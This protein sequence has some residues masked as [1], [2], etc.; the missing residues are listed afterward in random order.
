MNIG[1]FTDTYFPQVN[2]V[3]YTIA[4]WK[5]KLEK[6]HRVSVYYP[7]GEYTPAVGEYP[8][9]SY[10]FR[11]YKGYNIAFPTDV[12]EKA[13]GLD[14]VHIH[15]LFS[16]AMAG[17]YV[18]RK[19]KLPKILTY[20]TPA[21]DYIDYMT[22]NRALKKTLMKLYNFWE[23][24]LLNSC[25][26][27]TAPTESIKERLEYKGVEDVMVLSNG[28][29][30]DLFRPVDPSFFR[31]RHGVGEGRV[32]GFCGRFGYEKHLEDLIGIADRFD[33]MILIAGMGPAEKYY[34]RLAE[35]K[36]NVKFLGFLSKEE[37]LG[38]YSCL[39]LFVFPSIAETQGLVALE[40]MACGT[41]VVGAN[42]LALTDTIKDDVVGYLYQQGDVGDLLEKIDAGY[43]NRERLSRNG[44]EYVKEHSVDRTIERLL[45]IYA[46]LR[47]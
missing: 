37:I 29:D 32:V 7:E 24:K 39:D 44:L 3:T 13:R 40:S 47:S 5:K 26:V 23:R 16:M 28:I 21:D 12:A 1:I 25:D 45:E 8:F 22:R 42:A 43:S 33:G 35:G 11:F 34:K 20:H 4:S 17:L 27:V 9:R 15:G 2:G 46:G 31:E 41:P 38:F 18:S 6:H 14:I 36:D 30:L 19:Y 10:E